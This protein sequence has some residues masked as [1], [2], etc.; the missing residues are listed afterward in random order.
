MGVSLDPFSGTTSCLPVTSDLAED[1]KRRNLS[2]LKSELTG[3]FSS[4]RY[5][6]THCLM[7]HREQELM[8]VGTPSLLGRKN[9]WWGLNSAP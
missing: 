7:I 4:H 1:D 3:I 5:F 8:F 6:T 2:F 9:P